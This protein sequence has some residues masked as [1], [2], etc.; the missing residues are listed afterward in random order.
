MYNLGR[1]Y[2]EE[3]NDIELAIVDVAEMRAYLTPQADINVFVVDY[4]V[5]LGN[6]NATAQ[7]PRN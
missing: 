7:L 2:Y 3:E 5:S 4:A 1:Y 6:T